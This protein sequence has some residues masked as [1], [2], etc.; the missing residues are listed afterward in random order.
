MNPLTNLNPGFYKTIVRAV[1]SRDIVVIY[2][3][4]EH[5]SLTATGYDVPDAFIIDKNDKTDFCIYAD[6]ITI[7]A[8]IK[9]P[10]GNITIRARELILEADVTIDTSSP[11]R[12]PRKNITTDRRAWG[13]TTKGQKPV[14]SQRFWAF[15]K[16]PVKNKP[17]QDVQYW[18]DPG[19]NPTLT[20]KGE[21][22]QDGGKGGP[23]G[24]IK[25]IF[26][27][28]V[29]ENPKDANKPFQLTLIANG[30]KGQDGQGGMDGPAS[31]KGIDSTKIWIPGERLIGDGKGKIVFTSLRNIKGYPVY[32][33]FASAGG[34]GGDGGK[35]GRG[36]NGG[37]SGEIIVLGPSEQ[38]NMIKTIANGGQ[39]GADGSYGLATPGKEGGTM[40]VYYISSKDPVYTKKQRPGRNGIQG[41]AVKRIAGDGI[42]K[43]ITPGKV[44]VSTGKLSKEYDSTFLL[45]ML[46]KAKNLFLY[47]PPYDLANR[48]EREQTEVYKL[49]T[50]INTV[51]SVSGE[52]AEDKRKIEINKEVNVLKKNYRRGKNIYGKYEN[53]VPRL[54]VDQYKKNLTDLVEPYSQ[55]ESHF[56]TKIK[57]A[58]VKAEKEMDLKKMQSQ[59]ETKKAI[60]TDKIRVLKGKVKP[61]VD[62][63][64][65][66]SESMSATKASMLKILPDYDK[67]IHTYIDCNLSS[68]LKAAEMIAFDPENLAMAAVQGAKLLNDSLNKIEGI[69]ENM[70]YGD[71]DRLD[72]ML[73]NEKQPLSLE[74]GVRSQIDS[75]KQD[76]L[77]ISKLDDFEKEMSK[78]NKDLYD[79]GI[80]LK[81][82]INQLKVI[83]GARSSAKIEYKTIFSMILQ[84]QTQIETIDSKLTTIAKGFDKRYDPTQTATVSYLGV[85]YQNM[86]DLVLE[87]L[88]DAD[89]AL[90]FVKAGNSG[91]PNGF[92]KY[93]KKVLWMNTDMPMQFTADDLRVSIVDIQKEMTDRLAN[94]GN[95]AKI[96]PS[97]GKYIG[98]IKVVIDD[99]DA[100]EVIE[101]STNYKFEVQT[102]RKDILE[103]SEYYLEDTE[104]KFDIRVIYVRPRL[105]FENQAADHG[106][107][108]AEFKIIHNGNTQ[109]T[110][111]EGIVRDYKHKTVN[112][113]FTQLLDLPI[114]GKDFGSGSNGSLVEQDLNGKYVPDKDA[115]FAPVGAF[116][117]WNFEIDMTNSINKGLSLDQLNRIE[118]EFGCSYF[119]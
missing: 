92:D 79:N 84:Y 109:L 52:T 111:D 46:Q 42:G 67:Q 119:S 6:K 88:F 18:V 59:L 56:K 112:T 17:A 4:L 29:T 8:P 114:D 16:I 76:N 104:D 53:W 27:K 75:G 69:D 113:F 55:I 49:F 20:Y 14:V 85:L 10:V 66:L 60:L 101:N 11:D 54:K 7:W 44:L 22:G 87:T 94:W 31:Y 19:T 24:N 115:Y 99:K 117:H 39:H 57:E 70:L 65:D 73:N 61:V 78:V 81:S 68:I 86:R 37:S 3:T 13:Q 74:N 95:G 48:K 12:P 91:F 45:K 47:Q 5:F 21:D 9:L 40:N 118:I 34:E 71:I 38:L 93:K 106:S 96:E 30:G 1:D 98:D 50:W 72:D 97:K 116:A 32:S 28:L 23:G 110:D 26:E 36:G 58:E 43:S 35:G 100:L 108:K 64:Y 51:S 83:I 105:I 15:D 103:D 41:A 33:R 63:I 89:R 102:Q 90:R 107:K 2:S 77:L 25:I 80:N 62:K 82:A